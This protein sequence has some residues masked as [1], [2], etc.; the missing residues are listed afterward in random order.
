MPA[1]ADLGRASLSVS[2]R[3]YSTIACLVRCVG[4]GRDKRV[5]YTVASDD[6]TLLWQ[7]CAPYQRRPTARQ[8]AYPHSLLAFSLRQMLFGTM[9]CGLRP[10]KDQS[11]SETSARLYLTNFSTS[12][13]AIVI[14]LG[15]DELDAVMRST[16]ELF[17]RIRSNLTAFSEAM[18]LMSHPRRAARTWLSV[19]SDSTS[20]RSQL[21]TTQ[22]SVSF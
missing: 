8:S 1:Q 21:I 22:A 11:P 9:F 2:P 19:P 15:C 13:G 4:L 6:A 20:P 10:Q 14:Q 7:A 16:I 5:D 12:P 18:T 17:A 3:L